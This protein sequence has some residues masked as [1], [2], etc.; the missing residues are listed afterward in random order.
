MLP[1]EIR[2]EPELEEVEPVALAGS[3]ELFVGISCRELLFFYIDTEI[4]QELLLLRISGFLQN[5]DA[6]GK[7]VN[8]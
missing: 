1:F 6:V 4:L 2:L 8:Y 5:D 3:A 7:V